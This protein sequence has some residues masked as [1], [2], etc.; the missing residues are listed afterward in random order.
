[1]TR[2]L[3]TRGLDSL[4]KLPHAN[5]LNPTN[6]HEWSGSA[7]GA[8]PSATRRRK[9]IMLF[10]RHARQLAAQTGILSTCATPCILRSSWAGSGGRYAFTLVSYHQKLARRL[11]PDP[12]NPSMLLS[13]VRAHAPPRS[14]VRIEGFSGRADVSAVVS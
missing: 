1:M 7:I 13:W 14:C 6:S 8:E 5:S 12:Y 9:L 4:R 2:N 11:Y 3:G 10:Q